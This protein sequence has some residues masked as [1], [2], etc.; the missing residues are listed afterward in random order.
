MTSAEISDEYL[1][2]LKREVA[3]EQ[4][5]ELTYRSA[6]KTLFEQLDD[7][8]IAIHEPKRVNVGAPDFV[9][10]R[11]AYNQLRQ[12]KLFASP[13][14]ALVEVKDIGK[15][16]DDPQNQAQL[17][18]YFEYC[19]NIIHT[20]YL[21]FRFYVGKQLR[22]TIQLIENENGQ[23]VIDSSQY[24]AFELA[25]R[26]VLST[27]ITVKNAETLANLMA[28]R[29]R[30]I[31]DV[32]AKALE[33]DIED[34]ADSEIAAQFR[35]FQTEL[36]S[37][38]THEKF[39][40]LYAQTLTYGLFA[41]RYHDQT[42][43]T[44]SLEEAAKILPPTNPF[45]QKFFRE[46]AGYE[47]EE[48][49]NWVLD[50]LVDVFNRCDVG[51]LLKTDSETA[52]LHDPII[53][54]YETFLDRYDPALRRQMGVY[55]TPL[56]VVDFIVRQVDEV[57]KN[58]FKLASGLADSS[59]IEF[60]YKSHPN[61][62]AD[63]KRGYALAK[64]Q[65]PRVQILDPAL[66][67]GTFLNETFK[68]IAAAKK[69]QLGSGWS[70]YVEGSLLARVH[71]FEL[72][73]APYA[74]SHLR[75]NLT[76]AE[77]GYKP[78]SRTPQRLG[79]YL[80][81]TLA[82][83]HDEASA[84]PSLNLTGLDKI[85]A[86]E[87]EQADDIKANTPVMVVLG[88]PP[89]SIHSS[90]PSVD[91][92]GKLTFIGKLLADYK[93]DLNERKIN[94]DDDY[95]KFI[96]FAEN[97][98][99]KNGSGVLAMI[100]N[101]SYIDGI[102]HRQMRKHLL[103]TFDKI[104]ILNLHGSSTKSETAPDGSKDENVF[105]IQQGVAI[106]LMVTTSQKQNKLGQIYHAEFYG[107][108][109][110]KFK[111]LA[112]NINFSKLPVEEPYYFF[113]PKDF[114]LRAEYERSI[115][116]TELFTVYSAGIKTKV[117]HIATDFKARNLANRVEDIIDNKLTREEIKEKYGLNEK[118]TWEYDPSHISDFEADKLVDYEYRP[119]DCRN[120]YYDLDF[121]SR[122][123]N[124]V[125]DNF[126][127][128]ENIGLEVSRNGDYTFIGKE[129]SDEHYVS[130]N[131]FK[132]PLYIYHADG[133][134]NANFDQKL[135]AEFTK[136]LNKNCILDSHLRG[137]DNDGYVPENI[138]DYIYAVLHSPS[139]CEKYQEFLKIDFP[140]V[141]APENDQTF[142]RLAAYGKKLRQLHLLQAPEL[143]EAAYTP[144]GEG[145]FLL[146][147]SKIRYETTSETHGNTYLNATQ[148]FA[149]VPKLAWNFYIG[150]YQPAQKY[151]KDRAARQLTTADLEH[152][153]KII[154]AL[155]G[156]QRI[157][158][159]IDD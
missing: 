22:T 37:D 1:S 82:A 95:I 136:N 39:A 34:E 55:Y 76:L 107:S 145:D 132:L 117:D 106:M 93:K 114:G 9:I 74:I 129:I 66:G 125:M 157:M 119:F 13:S 97:M 60:T 57:L 8:I 158:E 128:K 94:L 33:Q 153:Q 137:K 27:A 64:K 15:N 105:N 124:K 38:L 32:I 47:R 40:D 84:Q 113:V 73:M 131:S 26:D 50:G 130:D 28:E 83:P 96:C 152:Y 75:L 154:K 101:N 11:S 121:L 134:R 112:S 2:S 139:Y 20:D 138:L 44:F 147:K 85:I 135:L 77:S 104:Y 24:A 100:T 86:S 146:E 62:K 143:S 30:A 52:K 29:A 6:L 18:R 127:N 46:I 12:A 65:I 142:Q 149:G 133:T 102:T 54:F 56:S 88:N 58:E 98:I 141:P 17:K 21:Q 159:Q 3:H 41:A 53:H 87:S 42:L 140:R 91:E 72:M 16:L 108:R 144:T 59:Q 7:S 70:K 10:E 126:Y 109:K 69:T 103:E 25:F 48:R 51:D 23:L 71:G 116:V 31:R 148:Y 49:I 99:A 80:T 5:R 79:V 155:A 78:L 118:T 110:A 111:S 89:Y 115:K 150:G 151:L 92:Q 122:A 45:L 90:N 123:R 120:I 61:T 4:G 35:A 81:N 43:E 67:T 68:F 156:T 63:I 14:L 19:G 36:V